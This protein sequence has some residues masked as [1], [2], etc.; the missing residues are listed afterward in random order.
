MHTH[1]WLLAAAAALAVFAA[2][3]TVRGQGNEAVSSAVDK[4]YR[5]VLGPNGKFQVETYAF[6][7]GGDWNG[8]KA[9]EA[10]GA[11]D[12]NT[13]ARL[14]VVPL[15]QQRFV[16]SN[17]PKKTQLLIVIYW[18][19][20]S[21]EDHPEES[22]FMDQFAYLTGSTG[23]ASDLSSASINETAQV[24]GME[25][26]DRDAAIRANAHILGFDSSIRAAEPY[27]GGVLGGVFR[28]QWGLLQEEL[29]DTR[30]FVVLKAYDFQSAWKAKQRVLR[31]ETRFSVSA[32]HQP[33]DAHLAAMIYGASRYFGQSTSGV[34]HDPL[35]KGVVTLGD[36]KSLGPV[37]EK[38]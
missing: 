1:D 22:I 14:V 24:L 37:I 8:P 28:D 11:V 35:P 9:D 32:A 34:V 30:Y 16:P 23:A 31:W 12:F 18:G 19:T 10:K 36:L 2:G 15:A 6:G 29:E 7:R 38:K 26:R 17:D 5:R 13:I 3:P 21:P 27:E 25:E 20:T 4:S 33:F